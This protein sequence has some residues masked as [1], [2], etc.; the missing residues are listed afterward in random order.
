MNTEQ[1]L[2]ERIRSQ[3][4]IDIFLAKEKEDR[5]K[6]LRPTRENEEIRN[7]LRGQL[8]RNYARIEVLEQVL[9]LR[10]SKPSK[11]KGVFHEE[12]FDH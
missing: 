1:D 10:P 7:L 4:R 12:A 11:P 6:K 8:S 2:R 9:Y 3:I 5:L